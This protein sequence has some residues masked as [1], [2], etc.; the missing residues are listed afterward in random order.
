MQTRR[1]DDGMGSGIARPSYRPDYAPDMGRGL[2]T[3][4]Q[5]ARASVH[6]STLIDEWA[7]DFDAREYAAHDAE[8]AITEY[9]R[10][11]RTEQQRAVL[12]DW[13]RAFGFCVRLLPNF[14][15]RS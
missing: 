8:T 7:D 15:G 4:P 5:Y 3:V 10:G 12:N 1:H 2:A 6:R 11:M 14:G 13:L 9:I